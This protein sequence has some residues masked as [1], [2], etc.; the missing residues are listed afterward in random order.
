MMKKRTVRCQSVSLL[1]RGFGPSS[2]YLGF[3]SVFVKIYIGKPYHT[4]DLVELFQMAFFI[5]LMG[6]FFEEKF[7]FAKPTEFSLKGGWRTD[8]MAEWREL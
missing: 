1:G 6:F 2:L 4:K 8:I 3:H 7:N 5:F